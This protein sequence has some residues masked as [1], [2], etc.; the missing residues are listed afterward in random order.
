M[1]VAPATLRNGAAVL[2]M[3]AATVGPALAQGPLGSGF[4]YQGALYADGAPA[5]GLYDLQF[6]MYDAATGGIQVGPT[7]CIDN[8]GVVEGLFTAVLDFGAPFAGQQRFLEIGVRPD[9]G[10]NCGDSTGFALLS[11][12]QALTATPYALHALDAGG[13][14]TRP[15]SSAAPGSGQVL[16]WSGTAWAPAA[17]GLLLPY[18]G[19]G[20]ALSVFRVTNTSGVMNAAGVHGLMNVS[21]AGAQSAG[22][23][24]EHFGAGGA[25]CGVMGVHA[26]SGTGVMALT[27]GGVAYYGA[28]NSPTATNFG[29]WA[30]SF[31]PGGRGV[32]GIAFGE[33]GTTI[34]GQFSAI[35]PTSRALYANASNWTG[36][37][38]GL[39]AISEGNTGRGVLGQ[40]LSPSGSTFGGRFEA[41]STGARGV[42]GLAAAT[43][44]D[45]VGVFAQSNS[46]AGRGVYAWSVASSGATYGVYGRCDSPAGF[47]VFAEGA[48]GAS[49]T[50]SFCIDHP[51]DPENMHLLHYSAESPDVIN[52]YS[53][54]ILLDG[55]GEAV[56]ELPH[57][58]AKI[59]RDP[60]YALTAVGAPMPMLHVAREIDDDALQVGQQ[61]AAGQPAP[62]C[63]FRIAGGAPHARVSWR[64]DA[65]RNDAWVRARG[66]PVELLK[67][68][69]ER[70][71]YRHPAH[72]G[73]GEDRGMG[74]EPE[75]L[76][77]DDE[78]FG[79]TLAARPEGAQ[80]LPTSARRPT[81]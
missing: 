65:I 59:N 21:Q 77:E 75:H 70:G 72:Y 25:G 5:G 19:V 10:Q 36:T 37:N 67:A 26:N 11:P 31:G 4:T 20:G 66:A 17:D 64:V 22:V 28:A 1:L 32:L 74:Y 14:R 23:R 8:V 46:T 2:V 9:T 50:K 30:E 18:D 69:S 58:F 81:P 6:R 39:W 71:R 34:G 48:L 78:D 52:F 7:L 79:R 3:A 45:A 76:T 73:H 12:R 61:S 63:S 33:T 15:V 68:G 49:G 29:A 60:R 41:A 43:T 13:L 51:D 24:G 54:T 44:G 16:K 55:A 38:Y 62:V 57:Y 42:L 47:G 27:D 40:A 35:A 80:P 56:V 53:G